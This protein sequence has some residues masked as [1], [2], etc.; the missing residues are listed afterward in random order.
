MRKLSFILVFLLISLVIIGQTAPVP[1]Q[2]PGQPGQ[3]GQR[4]PEGP[5]IKFPMDRL[6][7]E[8]DLNK[9]GTWSNDESK[10]FMD[11][12]ML[13]L[14]EPHPVKGTLDRIFD[15]NS[16]SKINDIELANARNMFFMKLL[17]SALDMNPDLRGIIFGKN[18][19]NVP[20]QEN[21]QFLSFLFDPALFKPRKVKT[22]FDKSIDA[23]NNG[24]LTQDEL[25]NGKKILLGAL[26]RIISSNPDDNKRKIPIGPVK[27]LLDE[28]V[29][30]NK[31][32]KVD[33][34]E[35]RQ[36]SLSLASP[37]PVQNPF[38]QTIDYNKN[39][40]IEPLELE[41]ALRAA[42]V[43]S[44]TSMPDLKGPYS[45]VT[46][47]DTLLDLNN[48]KK[49]DETEISAFIKVISVRG[50][51]SV[52]PRVLKILDSSK[53][54]LL[55]PKELNSA[56]ETFFRPHPVSPK[57]TMDMQLDKN[58]DGFVSPEEIGIP[59]G[60]VDEGHIFS[61]D[62]RLERFRNNQRGEL[63]RSEGPSGPS[64]VNQSTG[65]SVSPIAVPPAASL[66]TAA[67]PAQT[68]APVAAATLPQLEINLNGKRLAIVSI[69]DTSGKL[70]AEEVDGIYLF[71]QNAFI[72]VSGLKIVERQQLGK[73]LD[74]VALAL[75]L[76]DQAAASSLGKLEGVDVVVVGVL[77]HVGA[78][79]YLNIRLI[80]VKDAE[81]LGSSMSEGD[82]EDDFYEMSANAVIKMF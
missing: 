50:E 24:S 65:E 18:A 37:H 47:V 26:G 48:D 30:A 10:A 79:Y 33:E 60:S 32:G 55:E 64:S 6:R 12:L 23:N 8:F 4:R 22:L 62:E 46:A 35:A 45:I 11:Q 80:S 5:E 38:D 61:F 70:P 21:T 41:K 44:R 78:K 73:V 36:A 68:A 7:I 53:N 3:P 59:A 74:E 16:D 69:D 14:R 42:G 19:R 52:D 28:L 82:S 75:E 25:E 63:V 34:M 58:K 40:V 27:T 13:L 56:L 43:P 76:G 49:I 1:K 9:D 51:G 57:N 20:P 17:P 29:D 71:V 39:G 2:Q 66:N 15:G 54:G 81:I 67:A 77:S 72:N 31:D